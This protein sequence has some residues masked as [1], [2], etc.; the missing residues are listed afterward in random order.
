MF[1]THSTE[2]S[3]E[4]RMCV[5]DGFCRDA[6]GSYRVKSDPTAASRAC[7]NATVDALRSKRI[8]AVARESAES[9]SDADSSEDGSSEEEESD[10]DSGEY[11]SYS[12]DESS[13]GEFIV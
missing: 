5:E 10:D 12:S 4:T 2:D 13:E 1:L 9:D 6:T 7:R 11:S 3:V 8:A